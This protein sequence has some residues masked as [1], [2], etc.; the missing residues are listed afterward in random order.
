[1]GKFDGVLL[2]SD[3]DNT[4]L[5]TE[6]ALRSGGACPEMAR[7]NIDGIRRFMDQGGRF[8]V[9]TGRA[10]EAYRRYTALVP[11]NAPTVVDNGGAIYDFE[12]ERYLLQRFLPDAA[13][14]DLAAI[15][16]RFPR[17]SLE[18]YHDS[19]LVQALHPSAWNDQHALL[20]GL[21]YRRIDSLGPET[22]PLP[23]AKALFVSEKPVLDA[24][25]QFVRERGWTERY[26]YIFS[27]DHLLE[28]TA[29]GANKGEMCRALKDMLGCRVLICAGDHLN[30]MSMLT[31]ADRAFCPA[32]AQ[33][34]VLAAPGIQ[35]V[36]H[37][38]EGAIG[39]IVELLEAEA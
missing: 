25:H 35:A 24:V 4:L 3:F 16:A 20:T 39:H 9:A 33:A 1:M 30:D 32:N 23:L 10:R 5:Y 22:V 15:A 38:T 14:E 21:P 19:D 12:R 18:L 7:R 2:V 36:C 27:S 17:V 34:E 6:G 11:T 31:A 28:M 13:R 8:A 26:E 29:K 37:C